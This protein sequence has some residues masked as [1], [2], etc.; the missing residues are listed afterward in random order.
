MSKTIADPFFNTHVTR[1]RE[2]Q[3][4]KEA[5]EDASVEFNIEMLLENNDSHE[6]ASSGSSEYLE[7]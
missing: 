5:A 3:Q 1:M 6:A 2:K 7:S 4:H